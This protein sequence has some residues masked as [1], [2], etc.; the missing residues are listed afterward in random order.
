MELASIDTFAK[1]T[2]AQEN[3]ADLA[4]A[5]R[6]ADAAEGNVDACFDLGVIYSTGSHG[7]ATDLV[8]AHMWFNLAASQGHEE[9]V[10]CRGDVAEEMSRAE[11]AEAQR[12]ARRW[13]ASGS[14]R[15][16]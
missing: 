11:I 8:E 12:R 9:A 3:M 10:W 2:P 5:R 16:A 15:A 7:A 4:I 13:L 14:R 6:I 1:V